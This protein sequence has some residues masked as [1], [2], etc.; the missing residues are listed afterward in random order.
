M[1]N[2]TGG[3]AMS[4]EQSLLARAR[5]FVLAA[6][7]RAVLRNEVCKGCL[8]VIAPH[9]VALE[10]RF[11][12]LHEAKVPL[13]GDVASDAVAEP[14]E[15]AEHQLRARMWIPSD[16]AAD[17]RRSERFL[18]Q[19]VGATHRL[20]FEIVG[21]DSDLGILLLC[22]EQD[23]PVVHAAFYGE[24]AR[25]ELSPEREDS[26]GAY[27]VDAWARALFVD[28]V[29]P[30][31]YSHLLT[32]PTELHVTPFE[33]L[34][35]VLARIPSP[36]LGLCQVLFQPVA[37]EHDW[38][39]NIEALLDFEFMIK[40]MDG[41]PVQ[42]YPQQGPSG[43]LRQM[44]WQVEH[45]AH[46]DKPLFA[47]AL[48]LAV[49]G[50]EHRG[51]NLLRSLSTFSHLYQHGGR[52]LRLLTQDNY[53]ALLGPES[54]REM[55][56]RGLTYRPGFLV[57]SWELTGLVHL[58]AASVLEQ[59]SV[60]LRVLDTL[61]ALSE[62]F[63]H[64]TYIGTCEYAG[65]TTAVRLPEA[66]RRCHTH[67]LGGIGMGKSL[68]L[69]R[70]I[71]DDL[72]AGAGVAVID[73]HGDLIERLLRLLPER[74]MDRIIY[75]D[76]GDPNWVPI[77]NPLQRIAGQDLGRMASDLVAAFKS[78]VSGWGDRMERFFREAFFALLHRPG[79]TLLDVSTILQKS[80]EGRRL[81]EQ[82][83]EL[84]D[85]EEPRQFWKHEFEQ[86]KKDDLG[87][88]KNKL[89]KLLVGGTNA[90]ML[91]QPDSAFNLRQVMDDGMI[92]LVNLSTLG[93][94]VRNTLGCLMLSLI[95]LTALGRSDTPNKGRRQFHVYCDEAHRFM[96]DGLEDLIAETQKFAVGLTLAHQFRSQFNRERS[97]ALS[98]TA[99]TI[100][101]RLNQTDAGHLVKNLYGLVATD[102]LIKLQKFEAIVRAGSEVVRIHTPEF[103]EIHGDGCRDRIIAE[104]RRRYYKPVVDVRR[105]IRHRRS[106]WD[107]GLV[108]ASACEEGMSIGELIYDEL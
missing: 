101:F 29:P 52:R 10:P 71:L 16:F 19:L 25:C 65:R 48:R 3:V 90:L 4:I 21:N 56:A 77:W 1:V 105:M 22:H 75:I 83:T 46:N 39:R 32:C 94:D 58:P 66:L 62:I 85:G 80:D 76:P 49:V 6:K 70:M 64:G 108:P 79:S 30:P 98:S 8:P 13:T 106:C 43:D 38:H 78:F 82:I 15:A 34:L 55:F 44:A 73:P 100:I 54:V 31:P 33:P 28:Y 5:P 60:P 35:A 72:A 95:H 97:D 41:V 89:S 103:Q 45:K 61:P 42:R 63:S 91:C 12:P 67:V 81:R 96:T 92:L 57:N 84:V 53:A 27:P 74:D 88:P 2:P 40:M 59:R 93:S 87:P 50:A 9:P 99:S 102:D 68:L 69:E 20:A 37:L 36:A 26:L 14:P 18:K 86:Y 23:L 107:V 17:W 51:A 47:A 104:S 7:A 24:F 11:V